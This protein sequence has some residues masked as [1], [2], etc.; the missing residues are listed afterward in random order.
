MTAGERSALAARLLHAIRRLGCDYVQRRRAGLYGV[1]EY[2]PL[3]RPCRWLDCGHSSPHQARFCA[4]CGRP[5]DATAP[6]PRR[7]ADTL[8]LAAYPLWYPELFRAIAI[9]LAVT[10]AVYAFAL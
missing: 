6:V 5:L 10:L 7:H 8:H 3:A 9:I 2:E 1:G 4:H